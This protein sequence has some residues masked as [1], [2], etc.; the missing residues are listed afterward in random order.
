[1]GVSIRAYGGL[2][3]LEGFEFDGD[4]DVIG[5]DYD[6]YVQFYDTPYF[7]GRSDGVDQGVPYTYKA[8]HN[9]FSASYSGYG[10]WREQLAKLVGYPK[11]FIPDYPRECHQIGAFTV[12]EGPFHELICFSDCEGTLGPVVCAKLAKDFAEWDERAAAQGDEDWYTAY[13]KFR[14]GFELAANTGAV[15]FS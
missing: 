6:T 14:T 2:K 7:K 1:M 8:S 5:V 9:M 3:P 13:K 4:G 10:R 12:A 11:A 15:G